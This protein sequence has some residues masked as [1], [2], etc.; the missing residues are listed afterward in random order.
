MKHPL[1]LLLTGALLLAMG[2]GAHAERADRD[3]PMHIEADSL[4]HDETTQTS[5]FTGKVVITKGTIV[6]RGDKVQVRQDAQGNQSGL[7]TAAQGQRAYFRQKRDTPKGAPVE[8]IEGEAEEIDWD[9]RAE[10]VRLQRRAELRRLRA[11]V[12][13]DDVSGAL[14]TYNTTT[15]VFSVDGAP[16][17]AGGTGDTRVRAMLAPKESP[18][19]EAAEQAPQA[20]APAPSASS[21]LAPPPQ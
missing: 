6:L 3:Q 19:P 5:V 15:D 12:L 1:A 8:Y 13:S 11:G 2:W 9:G 18:A 4:V 14:I 21:E 10:T 7:V 16:R 17:H 20:P